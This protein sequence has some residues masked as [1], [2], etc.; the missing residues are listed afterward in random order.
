MK[1]F[2][3]CSETNNVYTVRLGFCGYI[4]CEEVVAVELEPGETEEDLHAAVYRYVDENDLLSIQDISP[5]DP[6][7]ES[8]GWEVTISFGGYIGCDNT[9][10]IDSVEDPEDAGL[11]ALYEAAD[12][13][14]F[15]I[16]D[17]DED[18]E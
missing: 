8:Q 1:R 12:D 10:T 14:T 9:Y 5:I 6:E 3:R 2:I 13:V 15:E 16:V 7:D 4:G 17:E 18:E 11:D